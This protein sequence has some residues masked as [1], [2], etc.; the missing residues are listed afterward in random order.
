M[1][2]VNR[3]AVR[4]DYPQESLRDNIPI[5][6]FRFFVLMLL[7]L[8]SAA[9]AQTFD[10]VNLHAEQITERLSV[11][12][13]IDIAR[14]QNPAIQAELARSR[15]ADAE[16][17][18]AKAL[19]NPMILSDN[20]V[21]EDSY[22][23]GIQQNILLGGKIKNRVRV[24]QAKK[25]L[26]SVELR[27]ALLQLR[28]S[29]RAA[30]AE[31]YTIRERKRILELLL[32]HYEEFEHTTPEIENKIQIQFVETT[33]RSDLKN[34]LY[35]EKMAIHN[36]NGLLYKPLETKIIVEKP[37]STIRGNRPLESSYKL[38]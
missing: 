15:I 29:V 18:T 38:C 23:L 5:M 37:R 32:K 26:L 22:R 13:A 8:S 16:I 17:V 4:I 10:G 30:Y 3:T 7:F 31:L 2:D 28:R 11:D 9:L 33:T 34:V 21:A 12:Q 27:S 6:L 19:P 36:L 24:A 35:E 14:E 1:I 20:G 25:E